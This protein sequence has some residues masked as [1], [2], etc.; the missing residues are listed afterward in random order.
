VKK[1]ISQIFIMLLVVSSGIEVSSHFN[2]DRH[3]KKVLIYKDF[4]ASMHKAMH[5]TKK[6]SDF[7]ISL[8]KHLPAQ[9]DK[10][11]RNYFISVSYASDKSSYAK[12]KFFRA[13]RTHQTASEKARMPGAKIDALAFQNVILDLDAAI[14]YLEGIWSGRALVLKADSIYWLYL[15]EL[16]KS[17]VYRE[18]PKDPLWE[19][20]LSCALKGRQILRE[21]GS[22]A[23]LP[24]ADDIVNKLTDI[25]S[26]YK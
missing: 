11:S 22:D 17:K 3:L 1:K 9:T 15:A 12:E 20:G 2:S 25:L 10:L 4:N 19:E 23:D 26:T 7:A 6:K 16:T 21:R 24:W 5:I 18:L 8:L 13:V 14:P